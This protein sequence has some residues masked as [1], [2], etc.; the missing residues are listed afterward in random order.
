MTFDEIVELIGKVV[1]GTGV[2][3][4]VLGIFLVLARALIATV[5]S[6]EDGYRFARER[7]GRVIL[8][9]IEVL[10]AGD[11]IRTVAAPPTFTS[12]GVLAVI[13]LIR[14]FLSFA[15]ETELEGRWPW[16]RAAR[17]S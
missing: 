17:A 14:T 7:L 8:L 4:V 6:R 5:A 11:I 15:I 2:A 9:G 3:I 16:Q 13:V 12:V 1:E 10:V